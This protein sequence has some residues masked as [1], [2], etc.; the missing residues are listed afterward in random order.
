ME[1]V[2]NY[3]YLNGDRLAVWR[4]LPKLIPRGSCCS[5]RAVFGEG[6]PVSNFICRNR[7][8]VWRQLPKLIPRGSC[9][10]HRA[11]FGEG[12]PVSNFICRN[13]LAVWRQ[14]P[15]LIPAGSTPVSCSI[16]RTL[17]C[18]FFF[19]NGSRGWSRLREQ[20][21]CLAFAAQLKVFRQ[22]RQ[23]II[24]ERGAPPKARLPFPAP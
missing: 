8:A 9:C 7:L 15:K 22:S 6:T 20:T 16:K 23:L 19:S 18:V 21:L 2:Y 14:L 13:R 4:Q 5:H 12:T 1:S 11:A 17:S 10:S 3:S 24:V